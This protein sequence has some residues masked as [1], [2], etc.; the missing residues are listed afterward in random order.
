MNSQM[1]RPALHGMDVYILDKPAALVV[2]VAAGLLTATHPCATQVR[3]GQ[4]YIVRHQVYSLNTFFLSQC[5]NVALH[6][7]TVYTAAGMGLYA[8]LTTNVLIDNVAIAKR[9][10]EAGPRPMSITA[11]ALHFNACAGTI[12]IANS[13]F[14]G[15][16]DDGL[17]VILLLATLISSRAGTRKIR[18]CCG[19]FGNDSDTA[20]TQESPQ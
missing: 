20:G 2:D 19:D 9:L 5:R 18:R 17:N 4:H 6:D 12:T 10:T 15:Q 14:E 3:V 7:I 1:S 16:G 13:L 11:D 8:Q